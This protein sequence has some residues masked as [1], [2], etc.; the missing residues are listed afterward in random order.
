M[1]RE[2]KRGTFLEA[3]KREDAVGAE[4]RR[5]FFTTVKDGVE[6]CLATLE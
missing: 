1:Q 5:Q 2:Q 6:I 3:L 4:Q